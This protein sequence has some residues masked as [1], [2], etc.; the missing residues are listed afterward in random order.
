MGATGA[1]V[2]R[3][4]QVLAHRV[5]A[6][7]LDR[8]RRAVAGSALAVTALGIVDVPHPAAATALAVRGGHADDALA[9]VWGA[10]GA[11]ALHR[12][13]ELQALADAL[14][15]RSDAD[16]TRRLA[17]PR[18]ADGARLGLAAFRAVA[19]AVHE[20]LAAA[21]GP[22]PKAELSRGVTER[23]PCG[24]RH[25]AGSVLQ[26]AGLAGGAELVRAGRANAFRLLP[27]LRVPEAAAGTDR[28]V[29][30]Y[31]H[32]LGPATPADVA[33]CLQVSVADVRAAWPDGLAE[34]S[35]DG[36]RTWAPAEDAGSLT[37]A[38]PARLVRL[39]PPGDPWLQARDRAITVPAQ[40]H[41]LVWRPIGAPGVLLVDGEGWQELPAR[42]RSALAEELDL[43]AAARGAR[44]ARLTSC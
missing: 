37:S 35:V 39:L 34:F 40:R 41:R 6:Q 21:D 44:S 24:A 11:P 20:V 4:E 3:R 38:Q 33:G 13:A 28:L 25:V 12:R 5:R 43:L 32:L 26:A 36:R 19:A 10:R 29:R 18:I 30:R 17:N 1:V 15:P 9:L 8:P 23:V 22:V 14:W 31:L 27:D 16:A 42:V 7:E 2:L